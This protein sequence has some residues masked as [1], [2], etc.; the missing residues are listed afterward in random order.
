MLSYDSLCNS[1]LIYYKYYSIVSSQIYNSYLWKIL[2]DNIFNN[3]NTK[4]VKLCLNKT[5]FTVYNSNIYDLT[6][7]QKKIEILTVLVPIA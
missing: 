4:I 3:I 1:I 7:E 5:R 2:H 6:I